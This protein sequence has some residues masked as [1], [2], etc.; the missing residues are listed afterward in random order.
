MSE[1]WSGEKCPSCFQGTLEQRVKPTQFE[2][3][4][5]VMEYPQAAAWCGACGKGIIIGNEASA[6][7]SLLDDFIANVGRP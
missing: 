5:H 4:D 1:Q 7:E 3:R 2:Y 6:T